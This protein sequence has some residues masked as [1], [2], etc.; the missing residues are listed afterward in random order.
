MD[1]C[2]QEGGCLDDTPALN[3]FDQIL[4]QFPDGYQRR[5]TIGAVDAN[6]GDS[7]KFDQDNTAFADLHQRALASGS[8]PLI[9]PP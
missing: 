5:V 6:T 4:Q 3:L 9:F 8:I 1:G 2:L 7:V